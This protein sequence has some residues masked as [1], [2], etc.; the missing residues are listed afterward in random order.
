VLSAAVA[1]PIVVGVTVVGGPWFVGLILAVSG[2]AV[3][4]ITILIRRAGL[5]SA[6]LAALL[7]AWAFPL[8]VATQTVQVAWLFLA[9]AIGVGVMSLSST[10]PSPPPTGAEWKVGGGL[11][12]WAIS[13]ALALYVGT[14]LAPSIALRNSIDGMAW[15]LVI[16][17]ATWACD[18]AAFLV[19][20][21]WGRHRFAPTVSPNKSIEGVAAGVGAALCAV[22]LASA[23]VSQPLLRLL[24]LGLVVAGGA[25]AGD[26]TESALKRQLNAKD[27]GWMMPGHGGLLDRIDSLLVAI[28]LGYFYIKLTGWTSLP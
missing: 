19:G 17:V 26:L 13:V 4:E 2:L 7:A 22:A 23:F 20:R 15:M 1:I 18:T 24:G 14:L 10:S 28:F 3:W 11:H 6:P 9:V 8:S 25:V 5:S 16:L 27:S 12:G 21:Q